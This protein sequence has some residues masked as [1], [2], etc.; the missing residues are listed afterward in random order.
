MRM[1]MRLGLGSRVAADAAAAAALESWAY[2]GDGTNLTDLGGSG[3]DITGDWDEAKLEIVGSPVHG[4]FTQQSPESG[5]FTFSFRWDHVASASTNIVGGINLLNNQ[6]ARRLG[7]YTAS[8]GNPETGDRSII[9]VLNGGHLNSTGL[10]P[11]LLAL[12]RL[13][14]TTYNEI[15]AFVGT[16]GTAVRE[17]VIHV[18]E[19]GGEPLVSV[20]LNGS[21]VIAQTAMGAGSGAFGRYMSIYIEGSGTGTTPLAGNTMQDFA[22][23]EVA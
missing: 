2:P 1:D 17:I 18:D 3:G 13:E 19:N 11:N 12:Q 16:H 14:G 4:V 20:D 5:K 10:T 7:K 9:L 23:Q 8:E 22:F 15:A 21:E 6:N